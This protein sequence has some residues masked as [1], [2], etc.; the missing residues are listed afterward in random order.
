MAAGAI[1]SIPAELAGLDEVMSNCSLCHD[2]DSKK[3]FD[4][5]LECNQFPSCGPIVELYIRGLQQFML[6][7]FGSKFWV[8][9][10][11]L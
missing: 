3:G 10:V 9:L 7:R 8:F 6:A 2:Q 5:S 1:N 11:Y 4:K